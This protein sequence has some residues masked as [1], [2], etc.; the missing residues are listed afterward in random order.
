MELPSEQ[1]V[2]HLEEADTDDDEVS[3]T[4]QIVPTKLSEARSDV[5]TSSSDYQVL[6]DTKKK[7]IKP[8]QRF[9]LADL[10]VYA[11]IAATVYQGQESLIYKEATNNKESSE[12]TVAIFEETKIVWF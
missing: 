10:I 1:V 6:T 5:S 8:P 9:G 11:V 7:S 3:S 2:E 12:G 4:E